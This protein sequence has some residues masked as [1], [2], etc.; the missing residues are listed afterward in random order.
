MPARSKGL[1]KHWIHAAARAMG[2]ED[3]A[4]ADLLF[5]GPIALA[6]DGWS[7]LGDTILLARPVDVAA[8]E[9]A[10]KHPAPPPEARPDIREY[11]LGREHL[12]ATNGSVVI[13]GHPAQRRDIFGRAVLQLGNEYAASLADAE[14]FQDRTA[15]LPPQSQVVLYAGTGTRETST[16]TATGVW[17]P[18]GW[19]QF[20]SAAVAAVIESTGI[21]VHM[22][23][24]LDSAGRASRRTRVPV[25][26]VLRLPSSAII[27]WSRSIDYVDLLRVLEADYPQIVS[28][29]LHSGLTPEELEEGLLSHLVGDSVLMVGQMD[30]H[31]MGTDGT[32]TL[33]LPVAAMAVETDD[34]YL[35][36]GMLDRLTHNLLRSLDLESLPEGVSAVERRPL[37]GGGEVVSVPVGQVLAARS[38][39]PFLR[40][41][42]VSWT[43]ADRWLVVSSHPGTVQ[44]IIEA[45]RAETPSLPAELVPAVLR[46]AESQGA[47]GQ[48]LLI[49]R[50]RAAASMIDSWVGYITRHHP[51]MLEPQ[52]W[53]RLRQKQR[54]DSVQ[55]G[56]LPSTRNLPGAVE[57]GDTMPNYPAYGR[58]EPGDVILAVDGKPLSTDNPLSSLRE[59]LATRRRPNAVTMLVRRGG[60]ELEIDVPL[61]TAAWDTGTLRPIELLR[62]AAAVMRLFSSASYAVWRSA[63]EVLHARLELNWTEPTAT[64][65][66]P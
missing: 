34:P 54:L 1:P 39:C 19:P 31:P 26:S 3:A 37:A 62:K 12:L 18:E 21:A 15:E 48:M 49:A 5:S 4:T 13:I 8:L 28:M 40:N 51:E 27:A 2:I 45:R 38:Q 41:L 22:N 60:R 33:A 36:E 53:E 63:P 10:L 30:V 59:Q 64:R 47:A 23:G 66:G 29:V 16:G 35:V 57:V 20:E 44:A 7:G 65:T 52:W 50:P 14:D 55:L 17:W 25:E 11:H 56:I 6:A 46:E 61:Q 58:L 32:E 24:R 43:V 42:T 9:R